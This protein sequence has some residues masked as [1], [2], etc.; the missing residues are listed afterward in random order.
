[1]AY[2]D[3]YLLYLTGTTLLAQRFDPKRRQVFGEALSLAPSVEWDPVGVGIFSVSEKGMLAYKEGALALKLQLAWFDRGGRLI[4]LLDQPQPQL[5]PQLS[6]DGRRLAVWV[7]GPSGMSDLWVYNLSVGSKT[8]LTFGSSVNPTPPIWSPD[9]TLIAFSSDRT[10]FS[11]LYAKQSNG[12]GNEQSLL[13]SHAD[14]FP[15]DWSRDGRFLAFDLR[16]PK[17][18][19]KSDIWMLPLF[20]DRKPFAFLETPSNQRGAR[21]SPDGR[22]IAYT[23]DESGQD[24]I[25]AVP[26]ARSGGKWEVSVGG[27]SS[28]VWRRDGKELF[29]IAKDKKVMSAA[30]KVRDSSLV[31]AA[32]HPLFSLGPTSNAEPV[33]DVSADGQRFIVDLLKD[34]DPS[35]F[36]VVV[37]WTTAL[38]KN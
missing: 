27:G 37:N 30:L 18:S 19:R 3:G 36:T 24:E 31:I 23:S 2:A 32:V 14:K 10:G 29:Y 11:D 38:P 28:P 6:P 26:F 8:Q 4:N 13:R 33:Y 16:D 12:S 15:T 34:Q 7:V 1:V 17:D 9:G 35:P 25:Y 20:G 21:F 5:T 22:W